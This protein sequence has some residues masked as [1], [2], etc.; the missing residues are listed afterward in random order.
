[1]GAA[2]MGAPE[3]GMA[4]RC[5][6]SLVIL[7]CACGSRTDLGAQVQR[8]AAD[9]GSA[10]TDA[11]VPLVDASVPDVSTADAGGPVVEDGGPMIAPSCASV[12]EGPGVTHCFRGSFE[13]EE[14]GHFDHVLPPVTGARV[15]YTIAAS[16]GACAHGADGRLRLEAVLVGTCLHGAPEEIDFVVQERIAPL[17]SSSAL[18]VALSRTFVDT[19]L[20]VTLVSPTHESVFFAIEAPDF[21]PHV[22]SDCGELPPF[23]ARSFP[24]ATHTL[25]LGPRVVEHGTG[26]LDVL[27]R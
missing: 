8:H 13:P 22:V 27:V 2:T 21:W 3:Q 19:V 23:G 12:C 15:D 18:N 4:P 25:S 7:T 24:F 11:R 26:S 10:A 14:G 17:F 6:L 9:A 16:V 20:V 5:L 1:M